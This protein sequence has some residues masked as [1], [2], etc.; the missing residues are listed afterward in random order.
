MKLLLDAGAE[1]DRENV[2]GMTPL[3]LVAIKDHTKVLK[4]LLGR[5]AGVDKADKTGNTSLKIAKCKVQI[6]LNAG[7][8][9]EKADSLGM[10]PLCTCAGL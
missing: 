3:H 8:D 5:E 9:I 7:A 4:I 2:N 6:L 1:V 10:T